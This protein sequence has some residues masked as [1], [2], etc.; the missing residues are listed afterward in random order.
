MD[1]SIAIARGALL[2]VLLVSV[3]GKPPQNDCKEFQGVW[4]GETDSKRVQLDIKADGTFHWTATS[5]GARGEGASRIHGRFLRDPADSSIVYS[6]GS[7]TPTAFDQNVFCGTT[8][9]GEIKF[10]YDTYREKPNGLTS[11][12]GALSGGFYINPAPRVNPA[13]NLVCHINTQR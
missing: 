5:G 3:W 8:Q 1:A 13:D 2:S 9:C 7:A 10:D 4:T 12:G 11:G 6:Y